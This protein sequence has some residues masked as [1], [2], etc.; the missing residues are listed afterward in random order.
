MSEGGGDASV[1]ELFLS[2]D[3]FDLSMYRVGRWHDECSKMRW[4]EDDDVMIIL[5]A[6]VV[7]ITSGQ[8]VHLLVEDARFVS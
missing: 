3:F 1:P 4:L 7:V 6:L 2:G 5:L 8:E